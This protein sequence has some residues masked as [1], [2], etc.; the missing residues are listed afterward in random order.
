MGYLTVK[1]KEVRTELVE[2]KSVFIAQVGRVYSEE[3]AKKFLENVKSEYKP[4]N[5]HVYAYVI[6]DKEEYQK[7]SDDGEPQGT[8]GHPVL[9]VIKRNGLTDVIVVVTRYFG[10]ILLGASGLIRAYSSAASM[11]VKSAGVVQKVMACPVEICVDYELF[12]KVQYFCEQNRWIM[13][14]ILYTDKVT[15]TLYSELTNVENVK[16]QLIDLC[17]NKC[18]IGIGKGAWYYKLGNRYLVEL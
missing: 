12:G 14:E 15:F 4:A 9:E 17:S 18:S 11:A 5:H 13:E 8:A 10:G 2:K 7:C 1:Q 16:N 3:Q 6:G